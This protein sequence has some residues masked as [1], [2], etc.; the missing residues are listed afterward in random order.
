[1]DPPQIEDPGLARGG[2]GGRV[3]RGRIAAQVGRD[4]L[5]FRGGGGQ[6]R[7]DGFGHGLRDRLQAGG[8]PV[9]AHLPFREARDMDAQPAGALVADE[10]GQPDRIGDDDIRRGQPPPRPPGIEEVQGAV[11]QLVFRGVE[12]RDADVLDAVESFP[13]GQVTETPG[14]VRHPMPPADKLRSQAEPHLLDPAAEQGRHG[15]ERP[16]DNRDVHGN[17]WFNL[18]GRGASPV[19]PAGNARAFTNGLTP[20]QPAAGSRPS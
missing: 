17:P 10:D 7:P 6:F 4:D 16:L 12:A 18:P 9:E 15:Q 14:N 5:D 19:L 3:E 8:V 2:E 11:E 20:P 1:M 13:R